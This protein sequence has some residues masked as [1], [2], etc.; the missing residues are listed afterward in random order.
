MKRVRGKINK[1]NIIMKSGELL[2]DFLEKITGYKG[3]KR[4]FKR[5]AGYELNLKNPKSFAEKIVWK[6]LYDRNPLIPV[7]ADKYKVREY[8]RRILG[9]KEAEDILIP[10]LYITDNS[11]TIPF[12]EFPEGYIIKPNHASGWHIIVEKGMEIDKKYIISQCKKWLKMSYGIREHEWAYQPIK[13]RIIIEKLLKDNRGKMPTDYKFFIIHGECHLIQVIYDRFAKRTLGMY[14]PYWEYLNVKGRAKKAPPD[15]PPCCLSEMIYMSKKLGGLFD[16]IRVDF[17]LVDNRIYLTELTNYHQEGWIR[18]DPVSFDFEL[19]SKWQIE[20]GY[21]KKCP[22]IEK[23]AKEINDVCDIIIRKATDKD[24][25]V[26]FRLL[27]QANMHYIPSPEMPS[28]TYENYFVAQVKRKVVGFCGYKILDTNTAKTEL[29]VVD[30][31]YR[32]RGIGYQLQV[33]RMKD[34]L[35]KG[36]QKLITNTDHPETIAWYKKHFGYVE[37]GKLKKLHRFGTPDIEYW[38]TLE[39]DLKRWKEKQNGRSVP[40]SHHAL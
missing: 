23:L 30:R 29:M 3:E 31:R 33:H 13:R 19:G 36:I 4:R 8:A 2:F 18:W 34:M 9:I 35:N 32:N 38:T 6:K 24:K 28:L 12:D 22:Y 21:W 7:V 11:E 37:V 27:K 40:L 26:I 15:E 16:C 25:P 14:K 20:P 17:C 1:V 39:V 10:M 5:V